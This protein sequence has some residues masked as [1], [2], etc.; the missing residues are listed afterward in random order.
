MMITHSYILHWYKFVKGV[1][2][3]DLV[4]NAKLISCLI[5]KMTLKEKK[6]RILNLFVCILDELLIEK[7]LCVKNDMPLQRDTS[8]LSYKLQKNRKRLCFLET[9]KGE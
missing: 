5:H 8:E 2:G 1:L 4:M 9:N 3:F 6:I 7:F